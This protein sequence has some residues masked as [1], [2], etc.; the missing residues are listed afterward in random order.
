MTSSAEQVTLGFT[1]ASGLSQW[2]EGLGAEKREGA[3]ES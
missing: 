2:T 3:K 1:A